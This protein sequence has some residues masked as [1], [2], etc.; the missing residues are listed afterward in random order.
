MLAMFCEGLEMGIGEY[1]LLLGLKTRAI[2]GPG[3]LQFRKGSDPFQ[4]L[5]SEALTVPI[6]SLFSIT[7]PYGT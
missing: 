4:P 6:L 3:A 1:Y 5:Q 2:P 7:G